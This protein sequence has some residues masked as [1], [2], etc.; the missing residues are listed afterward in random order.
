M[1]FIVF[2]LINK[3]IYK[4][5]SLVFLDNFLT[6]NYASIQKRVM[7]PLFEIKKTLHIKPMYINQALNYGLNI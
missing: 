3:L 7:N 2:Y 5:L 1:G 6:G 4:R